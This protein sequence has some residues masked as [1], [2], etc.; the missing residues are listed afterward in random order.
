MIL[1]SNAS[2]TNLNIFFI[3]AHFLVTSGQIVTMVTKIKI[4]GLVL[5]F[6][7]IFL[8]QAQNNVGIGT[9]S[10][11][12]SSV[13]ELSASNK[14]ILIPRITDTNLVT[15]PAEGLL[16]YL[17]PDKGF[18][19]FDGTWWVRIGSGSGGGSA[20]AWDILGNTGT[21]A[22]THF[23]GTTDNIDLTFRTNNT[24]RLRVKNQS[25]EFLNSGSSVFIGESAGLLDDLS[26]NTNV[27]IGSF[28]LTANT[29]GSKNVSLGYS[30]MEKNTLGKENV[31]IG[32][33]ALQ[34]N[35]DGDGNVA[36]GYK[37]DN[38]N[39][40]GDNN[41]AVGY[42]AGRATTAHTKSS[43]VAIGYRAGYNNT[44]SSNLFLGREAGSG[45][46]GSNK[47]YIDNSSTTTPLVYG[48][49]DNDLLQ[50]NGDLRLEDGAFMPNND[51]GTA[52]QMLIS[53][54][55]G[56][57]PAWGPVL[58]TSG[59][60]SFGKYSLATPFSLP[61]NTVTIITV[62]DADCTTASAI[63]ANFTGNVPWSNA[64]GQNIKILNIEAKAG[65]WKLFIE[66]GNAA[67]FNNVNIN[68]IAFY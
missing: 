16:I 12:A 42:E 8:T 26:L 30:A 64:Q 32:Q 66:N 17:N 6:F 59:L 48:E 54:G 41:T 40:G 55:A 45:S 24:E 14:G 25:L 21:L 53:Q 29:T 60:T 57:E 27:G 19:Y 68:F 31:A 43:T 50:V 46:A 47:L 61:A 11:D 36:V 35:V 38:F 15:S 3:N 5:M 28:S 37:A 9:T 22:S 10:P 7:N 39:Q 4:T 49:F 33:W 52:G 65:S 18:W 58:L 34:E 67:T 44:G 63:S 2:A 51:A 20:S 56:V 23:L 1:F 13:L 62:T